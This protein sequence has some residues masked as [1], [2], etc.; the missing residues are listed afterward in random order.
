MA[1]LKT[2]EQQKNNFESQLRQ[3]QSE[4][5]ILKQN[6]ERSKIEYE[7]LRKRYTETQGKISSLYN[8]SNSNIR[9]LTQE[10]ENLKRQLNDMK[11][12]VTNYEQDINRNMTTL[13]H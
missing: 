11:V 6:Y 1:A 3:I 2:L 10:N 12:S 8:D 9:Q 13:S 4:H 7:D 5:D